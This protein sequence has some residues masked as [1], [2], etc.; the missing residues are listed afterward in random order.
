M[1]N[2]RIIKLYEEFPGYLFR[3]REFIAPLQLTGRLEDYLVHEF[4]GYTYKE[5]DG[6]LLGISN[7]GKGQRFDIAFTKVI[8]ENQGEV[9]A[10]L[11]A[12]YLRN[13]HRILKFSA[14]DEI[15]TALNGL[16]DQLKG[17][18]EIGLPEFIVKLEPQ[19]NKIYGL[20]FASY[21]TTD[22]RNNDKEKFYKS[23]EEKA[24]EKGFS[25]YDHHSVFFDGVYE[26][27]EV[28]TFEK[29]CSVTLRMG[30]WT[31]NAISE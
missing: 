20:V 22:G 12:K 24:E 18:R 23:I 29:T 27:A 17:K 15:T 6:E 30:L 13:V 3:K 5:T 31:S 26:D 10:L 11:E 1:S 8:G 19:D 25:P 14:T 9:A 7:L 21:V 16:S 4:I 28:K 2:S